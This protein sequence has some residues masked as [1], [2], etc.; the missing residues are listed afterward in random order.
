MIKQFYI[1][2]ACIFLCIGILKINN[3]AGQVVLQDAEYNS[4]GG[5]T[6]PSYMFQTKHTVIF[7]DKTGLSAQEFA[8]INTITKIAQRVEDAYLFYKETLGFE[9]PGGMAQYNNKASVF[10]GPTSCGSGCGLIGAK[11][12]EVSGLKSIFYN[13]KLDNNVNRDVIIPYEFGR[14]FFIY[15][16][17][18]LYPGPYDNGIKNLGF[19]EGFTNLFYIYFYD[20]ILKGEQRLLNE[21]LLNKKWGLQRF[22]GYMNDATATPY[23]S[24]LKWEKAGTI[25]PNRYQGAI[26]ETPY[27]GTSFLIAIFEIIGK[28]KLFPKFFEIL[29]TRPNVVTV[30]DAFSNIA[31]AASF[32]ANENFYPF[33]K[34][35]VKFNL[36]N[37][38][39][40]AINQLPATPSKL[41][42]DAPILWFLSPFERINLNLKSTNYLA[43]GCEYR[44]VIDGKLFSTTSDGNNILTYSIMG[45]AKSKTITCQLL[46][47]GNIID[48]HQITL[49]KRHAINLLNYP[50][51]L[52]AYHLDNAL[53]YSYIENGLL[54]SK[55]LMPDSLSSSGIYYDIVFK[56]N[57]KYKIIGD[58]RNVSRKYV[59]GDTIYGIPA[60]GVSSIG[61]AGQMRNIG[62]S[63]IGYDIGKGDTTAFYNVS[64]EDTT[65]LYIPENQN[66]S[67]NKVYLGSSGFKQKGEFKN[68]FFYDITDTDGDGIVDFEDE[69]PSTV[70]PAKP[71]ITKT[72]DNVLTAPLAAVYLWYKDSILLEESNRQSIVATD[73][74]IYSLKIKNEEGCTSVMSDTVKVIKTI[75]DLA[76]VLTILPAIARGTT[77]VNGYITLYEIN[78]V[79]TNGSVIKL[80]VSK[81]DKLELNFNHSSNTVGDIPVN[82]S[83]WTLDAAT[84][85]AFYIFNTTAIIPAEGS[86]KLG[87]TAVIRP[88]NTRGKLNI[89]TTLLQGSGGEI[90]VSNNTDSESVDYFIN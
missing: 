36:N 19:A 75:P 38:V 72:A 56:K 80:L 17:K 88:G 8:D 37:D 42:R 6:Y 14:N 84:S 22:R 20:K 34:N 79:N 26:S 40:T 54:T 3:L 51:E 61:F 27:D 2:I 73:N 39:V 71:L 23:N 1:I 65:N 32:A 86:L 70:T 28:D 7:M 4:W 55:S 52:Y 78:R 63:R 49:I 60:T 31:Y 77:T 76:P 44:L 48:E 25:D 45:Q 66:Y 41:I 53:T 16:S 74:G 24:L 33:F 81:D 10:F 29:G 9:P 13:L 57:R 68:I 50:E 15:S 69:C 21:T 67:L 43:D 35:V 62:S 12:I 82:N 47:N 89:T 5:N 90:R 18:V 59:E 85:P 87:F 58:V 11:G 64:T 46:K 83:L 30:E